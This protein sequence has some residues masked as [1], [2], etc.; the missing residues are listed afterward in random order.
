MKITERAPSGYEGDRVWKCAEIELKE[1]VKAIRRNK[2]RDLVEECLEPFYGTYRCFQL[3][4][5]DVTKGVCW[6]IASALEHGRS[7][8]STTLAVFIDHTQALLMEEAAL[9]K[10]E[11]PPEEIADTPVYWTGE[12]A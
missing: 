2:I 11:Q 12:K 7:Y 9:I 3:I 5:G 8:G 6:S 10:K 1:L 4:V